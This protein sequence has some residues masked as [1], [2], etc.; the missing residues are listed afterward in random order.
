MKK[1]AKFFSKVCAVVISASFLLSSFHTYAADVETT[2]AQETE[3]NV[4]ETQSSNETKRELT[5]DEEVLLHGYNVTRGVGL[6]D[7][8]NN[9][10]LK[11]IIDED[12]EYFSGLTIK[13]SNFADTQYKSYDEYDLSSLEQKMAMNTSSSVFGQI[14]VVNVG[15]ENS[16]NIKAN[17]ANAYSKRF[18]LYSITV[19]HDIVSLEYDSLDDVRKCL[20]EP[21]KDDL[22]NVQSK[23][24]AKELFKRYGTHLNTSYIYGGML[25]ITNYSATT[26]R[27]VDLSE[28]ATL[29]TK[30]SAVIGEIGQAGA[31]GSFSEEFQQV[32]NNTTAVS[33]YACTGYGGSALES[34]ASI[35]HLFTYST[36]MVNG[37]EE[38][39]YEYNK[40]IKSVGR[41][42]NLVIV[43][44]PQD[45][46]SI[47]LWNLLEPTSANA[48]IR[49]YLLDAYMELCGDKYE[50]YKEKYPEDERIIGKS[51]DSDS[52]TP[53][54]NGIYVRTPNDYYFYVTLDD[55]NGSYEF[56]EVHTGE[57]LYLDMDVF[58]EADEIEFSTENCEVIDEKRGIFKVIGKNG[59]AKI[60][61]K[62]GTGE[63][64][65]ISLKIKDS[66]FEGGN[67]SEDYPY[68]IDNKNQFNSISKN[69]DKNYIIGKDIDFGGSV[70]APVNYFSGCLDGNYCK[71]SNFVIGSGSPWGLF[72]EI[73]EKGIVKNL[74][75]ENAGTSANESGFKEGGCDY[76]TDYTSDNYAKN[77]ISAVAAGIICGKNEGVISNCLIKN[78][79]IRDIYKENNSQVND[80]VMNMFVGSI[81]GENLGTIENSMVRNCR[82][83][84][85][86]V[87]TTKDNISLNINTGELVGRLSQ[88][89]RIESCVADLGTQ[90]S[91]VGQ[92]AYKIG[93]GTD[94]S[95]LVYSSGFIGYCGDDTCVIK[96]CYSYVRDSSGTAYSAVDSLIDFLAN[97]IDIG[98]IEIGDKKQDTYHALRAPFL[99]CGTNTLS[100]NNC[101]SYNSENEYLCVK[102]ESKN[103]TNHSDITDN[104]INVTSVKKQKI[105]G[106]GNYGNIEL[107]EKYFNYASSD[108]IRVKHL[109][110]G[111]RND[112]LD[113]SVI[114]DELKLNFFTGESF[115]LSGLSK[116]LYINGDNK[117]DKNEIS[118]IFH[119]KVLDSKNKSITDE[120]LNATNG[121]EYYVVISLYEDEVSTDKLY[122]TV[123]DSPIKG[124]FVESGNKEGYQIYYDEIEDY[125]NDWSAN[126]IDLFIKMENGEV[127]PFEDNAFDLS[128]NR[129]KMISPKD[130]IRYGDNEI[131]LQYFDGDYDFEFNYLLHVNKRDVESISIITPPNKTE[132]V[133]DKEEVKLDGIE[134][135]VLYS[136]GNNKRL[137]GEDAIKKLEVIGGKLS[138]GKNTVLV[139]FEGYKCSA[140]IEIEGVKATNESQSEKDT[141][142]ENVDEQSNLEVDKSEEKKSGFN[143]VV[144]IIPSV[145]LIAGTIV[146]LYIMKNKKKKDKDDKQVQQE[147]EN[148]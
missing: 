56:D 48:E 141:N 118:N 119:L 103:G 138:E 127:I 130:G 21:F 18:Q 72:G 122:L 45:S 111:K 77:S 94:L 140:P 73:S 2:S 82:I 125:I 97:V 131:K 3:Q 32:E 52:I 29:E 84:A 12:S 145:I 36:S 10:F 54:I 83:L 75:I 33:S 100:L 58:S 43:G 44:I 134:I 11:K 117:A 65:E 106:E 115:M 114:A 74:C 7:K 80:S 104:C 108:T 22:Y 35:G 34:G 31:S 39:G 96:D 41:G 53:T 64:P 148:K 123:K 99:I 147:Q 69:K 4:I 30:V 47:P 90:G 139:A 50:E 126:D 129:I 143:P 91:V 19:C 37:L 132:Y 105:D 27:K 79:Y 120:K 24:D 42:E 16:F 71:I 137:S 81:A 17:F 1:A 121:K 107:S 38:S 40:W 85:S 6:Y 13:T 61:F 15:L 144:I 102:P 59:Y 109:M 25:Q 26:D 95:N 113:F 14:Y 142:P 67:G 88:N 49:G 78:C 57:T 98:P 68:I 76:S 89:G 66:V 128:S 70:I 110:E 86:Y 46:K 136:D 60:Q 135:D 124:I 51:K 92:S 20:T 112:Y 5:E 87:N 93:K 55:I 23:D 63:L 28:G 133:V 8:K 62:Y 146:V 116:E 9:P 101:Y